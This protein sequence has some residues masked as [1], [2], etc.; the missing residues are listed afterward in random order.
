MEAKP[1][2]G[3]IYTKLKNN[4]ITKSKFNEY[5]LKDTV[6]LYKTESG[7]LK[8]LF[9]AFWI[10]GTGLVVFGFYYL[11]NRWLE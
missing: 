2:K 10:I 3:T 9:W 7:V 8:I 5:N 4:T 1:I 11:D 6:E